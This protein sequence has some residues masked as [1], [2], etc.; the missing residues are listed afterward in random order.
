MCCLN[1]YALVLNWWF[2]DYNLSGLVGRI[3]FSDIRAPLDLPWDGS[4]LSALAFLHSA[5]DVNEA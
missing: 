4:G 2:H 5:R 3:M 1:S